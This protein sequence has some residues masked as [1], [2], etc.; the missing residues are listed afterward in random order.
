MNRDSRQER[1][2]GESAPGEGVPGEGVPGE[3]V[4]GE[5][6]PGKSAPGEGV[7]GEGVP[8]E[9]VPGEGVPGE[10]SDCRIRVL[11]KPLA[12]QIAA[13]EVV[14]RPA[15]V[16][17]ELCEN[18]L[19]A[20][21]GKIFVSIENGGS[22]LIKVTDDGTGMTAAEA[23][24]ACRRHATSKLA[25]I[26]DLDRVATLGF[27]GEA[28]PSIASVSKLEIRTRPADEDAGTLVSVTGEGEIES[29]AVGC[30]PGTTV[31]IRDLFFN[32]PARKKF[33][34]RPATE[35]GHVQETVVRLALA[36][37]EVHFRLESD[38][39]EALSFPRRTSPAARA[40]EALGRRAKGGLFESSAEIGDVGA[41][42]LLASPQDAVNSGRWCYFFVN[43]RYVRDRMLLRALTTA[44]REALPKGRYPVAV[45]FI[46][47]APELVDVNVHPQ[48]FEVRFV[49]EREVAAA[50]HR[51]VSDAV[52][53]AP[54]SRPARTYKLEA[55]PDAER[56]EGE[57]DQKTE[58][59][60]GK[61]P[62]PYAARVRE[63]LSRYRAHQP[64]PAHAG[65]PATGRTGGRPRRPQTSASGSSSPSSRRPPRPW[66]EQNL[67]D[68]KSSAQDEREPRDTL[69][70]SHLGNLRYLGQALGTFLVLEGDGELVLIDQHAAHERLRYNRIR[71]KLQSGGV[72]SQRLLVPTRVELTDRELE[73]ADRL[74]DE[75]ESLGFEVEPFGES[76]VAVKSAPAFLPVS[77]R[78]PA[79][80]LRDLLEDLEDPASQEPADLSARRD[81]MAASLACHSSVRAG[82]SMDLAEV[83]A[84]L[85]EMGSAD[86]WDRCPH[87]RPVLIRIPEKELRHRFQR[88]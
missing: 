43:G 63:A 13:G 79:A 12:N 88:S 29:A 37:P 52:G 2:P 46:E 68:G 54:W 74:S 80:L 27:R 55:R 65:R 60:H 10:S 84:L 31:Q 78:D 41:R 77:E 64:E 67:A 59:D 38:G 73:V 82:R 47:L 49:K 34:K 18:S 3:G 25:G 22:R 62:G 32:V 75:L 33:L 14:E 72:A 83:E 66:F 19:D 11:P 24:L 58:T 36:N 5:S 7:P 40:E 51:A 39:R 26:S 23:A 15:S 28:L 57:A 76:S 48:K 71:G 9:G 30:A 85:A 44:H 61:E 50:V 69:Y 16:V 1:A 4:P 8:G 81:R 56:A 42:V 70:S 45:V 35:A 17:K 53:R 86:H 20:S 21:A 87:G 6:A